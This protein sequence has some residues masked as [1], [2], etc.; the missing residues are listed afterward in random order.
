MIC[1]TSDAARFTQSDSMMKKSQFYPQQQQQ[2]PQTRW[3]IGLNQGEMKYLNRILPVGLWE[4]GTPSGGKN[5]GRKMSG[6]KKG[7]GL[8]TPGVSGLPPG[9]LPYIHNLR[10]SS[11]RKK[12]NYSIKKTTDHCFI[13]IAGVPNFKICGLQPSEF[14]SQPCWLG[15]SGS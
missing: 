2:K 10:N 11:E 3:K 12:Q 1:V 7:G 8:G 5:G 4:G 15:H 13:W 9:K 14:P 6:G